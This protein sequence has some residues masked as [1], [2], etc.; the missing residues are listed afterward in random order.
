MVAGLKATSAVIPIG[1][2]LTESAANTFTQ[3]TIDLN[4]SP[5]DRE[6]FVVQ[7]VNLDPQSPD[8]IQNTNT[9]TTCSATSTGITAVGNL[10]S[11]NTI[12]VAQQRI[13]AEAAP[14]VSSSAFQQQ[15][16]ETPPSS[17]DFIAIIATSDFF[18][19][20]EGQ[21]N[22]VAKGVSGKLYGYR[23]RASADIYSAL[24]QSE[25]LSA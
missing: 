3:L 12:A 11:A 21:N 18:V 25:V 22:L 23:A 24:V 16:L 19:Q 8:A 7:A 5:L 15:S 9:A 4:L 6:V 10:G 17:M 14:G 20:V 1:F 2:S 13:M